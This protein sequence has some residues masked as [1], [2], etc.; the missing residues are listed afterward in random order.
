MG[1]K[2]A[3]SHQNLAESCAG[4][5]QAPS[6]LSTDNQHQERHLTQNHASCPRGSASLGAQSERVPCLRRL[7]D[8]D[9][10]TKLTRC[11][12]GG[13]QRERWPL[14]VSLGLLRVQV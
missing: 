1:E 13:R 7:A 2:V 4:E 5:R 8:L 9:R 3:K 11:G 6:R 12:G 10:F 14:R